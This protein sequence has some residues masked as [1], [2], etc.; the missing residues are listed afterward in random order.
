MKALHTEMDKHRMTRS[1]AIY[2]ACVFGLS[3]FALFFGAGN[4]IFPPAMGLESGTDWIIGYLSYFLAD[5]GLA[6]LGFYAMLKTNGDLDGITGVIG[7]VPSVILN[8]S[9]ILCVGP[10]LAIPRTAATSFEMGAASLP[11]G[12]IS[13]SVVRAIFSVVFFVIVFF[14]VSHPGK[15]VDSVGK[16]LTP[17]LVVA[18]AILIAA[19]VANPAAQSAPPRVGNL[20]QEGMI[21]GF[22]TMDMIGALVF[23]LFVVTSIKQKA[24]DEMMSSTRLA[25]SAGAI[26]A[27]LLFLTYGGLAY[28]GATTGQLWGD[29]FMAGEVNH[30]R[31]LSNIS[32]A[33][34]GNA[35]TIVLSAV[36]V[37]ACLT[38]AIGLVTACSK[39]I[40][41]LF[42]E[43]LPYH[44][45]AAGIC[46]F[47][48]LV[49]NLGLAEII[50]VSSPILSLVYP[51][52]IF[53][54]VM[55]LVPIS[56]ARRVLACRLG[57]LTTFAISLCELFCDTFG[58]Q[59]LSF[60]HLLPFDVFGFGWLVPTL[61]V[62]A[63]SYIIS[64]AAEKQ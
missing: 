4:L 50:A 47:S 51:V 37:L 26:A 5:V 11:L 25:L 22:Q 48:A 49:C 61:V 8:C 56:D 7:K 14:A 40:V 30:A 63:C 19:G 54:V 53:L 32:E 27:L 23:S 18:L 24:E 38:T 35:G 12:F 52:A 42:K 60:I 41:S 17:L 64:R 6:L 20:F 62:A 57:A 9:V 36:V 44:Y 34:L 13:D 55:R 10:F 45:V 29:G 3:L 59:E 43:R 1:K 33:V 31:F 28:L 16:Y 58:F 2:S 21:N 46:V 15:V 39:F